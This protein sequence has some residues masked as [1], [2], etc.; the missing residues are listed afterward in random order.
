[1]KGA[2]FCY[3]AQNCGGESGVT[4][5]HEALSHNLDSVARHG[6]PIVSLQEIAMALAEPDHYFLPERFVAFSCDDGTY[7][8]WCDYD[9]PRFGFQCGFANIVREHRDKC[10]LTGGN[11][12]TAFVIASP[13]ARALIDD[14]CYGGLRLSTEDWWRDACQE[15]LLSI[16]SHSW[17]HAHIALGSTAISPDS[18]GEFHSVSSR[19]IAEKQVIQ[20]HD[21]INGICASAGHRCSLFAYPYGHSSDYL[22]LEFLPDVG[23]RAGIVGAYATSGEFVTEDTNRYRIPR[24]VRGEHWSLPSE[25]DEILSA[26]LV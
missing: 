12:L 11:L 19:L 8:D 25:F 24:L 26:L 22:A 16:E 6:L 7:L 1:M 14:V 21:Y 9:H 20:A 17:D 18:L 4:S 10:G 2:V 3:H 23:M 13:Q 15:G 5:D